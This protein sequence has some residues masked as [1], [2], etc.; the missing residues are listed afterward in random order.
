MFGFFA[1]IFC[2]IFSAMMVLGIGSTFYLII[3]DESMRVKMIVA[4]LIQWVVVSLI[5]YV[6]LF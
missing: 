1:V 3:E 6:T 2:M 4:F 5:L